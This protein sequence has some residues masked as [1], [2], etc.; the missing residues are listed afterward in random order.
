ML[1]KLPTCTRITNS[2]YMELF[3]QRRAN[4]L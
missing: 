1:K 4:I 2:K 3:H